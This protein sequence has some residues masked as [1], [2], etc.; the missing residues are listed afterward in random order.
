MQAAKG[1]PVVTV[2]TGG[3]GVYILKW[4]A[5]SAPTRNGCFAIAGLT[6]DDQPGSA[7]AS[8]G[9]TVR[10]PKRWVVD[11]STYAASGT[12]LAQT[13]YTAVIC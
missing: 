13:F 12:R 6:D 4:R 3:Q 7:E 11:L 10:G 8:L 5:V 1:Q 2:G 9:F